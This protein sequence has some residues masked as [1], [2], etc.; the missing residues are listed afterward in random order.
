MSLGEQVVDSLEFIGINMNIPCQ[1][2]MSRQRQNL[3]ELEKAIHPRY[4]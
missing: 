4:V 2:D 1:G 3:K